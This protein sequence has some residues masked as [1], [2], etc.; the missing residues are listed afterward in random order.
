M[1]FQNLRI[2]NKVLLMSGVI[3]IFTMIAGV[4]PL[5]QMSIMESGYRS[6][7]GDSFNSI[8]YLDNGKAYLNDA[9]IAVRDFIRYTYSDNA[10]GIKE[11]DEKLKI[12][13]P[14]LSEEIETYLALLIEF[15]PEE[16][17]QIQKVQGLLD[18]IN[19]E[20][21]PL[22]K[23]MFA[24]ANEAHPD[25][26]NVLLETKILP[27]A[28]EMKAALYDMYAW[29]VSYME[30]V[31][32]E[33]GVKMVK[34]VWLSGAIIVIALLIGLALAIIVANSISKPLS[35]TVYNLGQI[36]KGNFELSLQTNR[37]DEIGELARSLNEVRHTISG[38]VQDLEQMAKKQDEEGD[39]DFL[40]DDTKYE[41]AYKSVT[42]GV[43]NMMRGT[44]DC[45]LASADAMQQYA[46]G[47]FNEEIKKFPGKK[48]VINKA[49]DELHH[50]LTGVASDIDALVAQAADGKLSA[51]ADSTKYEGDW[52]NLI[53]ALNRLLEAIV[54]PIQVTSGA[55]L[56]ISK[57]NLNTHITNDFKGDFGLL[58]NS[59]NSTAENISEYINEISEV[60][61]E[62]ANQNLKL[63]VNREY[64]GDFSKIKDALNLIL[65]QFNDV[66]SNISSASEQIAEG[67]R[68]ISESS[69]SL[70]SGATEQASAVE[71][72]NASIDILSEQT[73]N[74]ADQA[75]N[76]KTLTSDASESADRGNKEMQDLLKAMD[77][78]NESSSN[79]SKITK[80]I[81]DIAFQTN[82]LALNAAVEAARAG[83]HGKGFAVVAEEVRNLASRSQNATQE[84]TELIAGSAAEVTNGKKVADETAR[85]LEEIVSK[86]SGA[87]DIVQTI[88]A[89]SGEQAA[90]IKEIGVG[91]T[92]I[93]EVTQTNAATSEETA[94]ASQELSSQ[95]SVFHDMVSKFSLR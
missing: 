95:A 76:A 26:A 14:A 77:G 82:L 91:I 22:C 12:T 89:L 62:M 15:Y 20:F 67:S 3:L 71:E 59:L 34:T 2:K 29:E 66:I 1:K 94:S 81:E 74:T 70:S 60:L 63:S 87:S 23:D 93:S 31:V 6:F 21:R 68:Q 19:N 27:V 33:N 25:E 53:N 49:L 64:I 13:N 42:V 86:I 9:R 51:R 35:R 83:Q 57:G 52:K 90:A 85:A 84:I 73:R 54:E 16:T 5:A 80:V 39:I 4:F 45:I 92:Q 41:G 43:N 24:L 40:L 55:L 46:A 47:N 8:A 10:Q 37:G 30:D 38:L 88:A 28:E 44:V 79:I 72:L 32:A 58:K 65:N 17:E 69:I 61:M 50:N 56:E 75:M 11:V 7:L 36:V 78:I 48:A 18:K